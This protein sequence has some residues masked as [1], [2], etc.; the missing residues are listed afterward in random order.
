MD[1]IW[2]WAWDRHGQMYS[3]AIYAIMF[4]LVLQI[5]LLPSFV[6]VAYEK[7]DSYVEAAAVTVVAV[8]VLVYLLILPG[9]GW[10]GLA[11][12]WAAGQEVDRARALKATYTYA[13]RAVVRWMAVSAVGGVLLLVVVGVIAGASGR[14]PSSTGFWARFPDL[15]RG[16]SVCTASPKACCGR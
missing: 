16:L 13:R 4:P 1:R 9:L 2:Q 3:W 7:S 12:Q 6:V 5:Y 11:Q 14:G 10:S 15:S 8:Q